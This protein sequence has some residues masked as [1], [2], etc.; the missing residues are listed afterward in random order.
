MSSLEDLKKKKDNDDDSGYPI[1]YVIGFLL[2]PRFC[3]S[4]LELIE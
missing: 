4:H 3:M 1:R 2:R